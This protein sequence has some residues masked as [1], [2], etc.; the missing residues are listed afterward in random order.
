MVFLE[1]DADREI[2]LHTIHSYPNDGVL[3]IT[4]SRLSRTDTNKSMATDFS[5]I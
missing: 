3:V 5:R 1:S 2:R 4:E